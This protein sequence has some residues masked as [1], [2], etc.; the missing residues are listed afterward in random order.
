MAGAQRRVLMELADAL[1]VEVA[2]LDEVAAPPGLANHECGTARMGFRPE[3]S[4]V[5]RNNECWEARGLFL[6][7]GACV[8]SQGTQNPTLTYLAL[9]ARACAYA[10]GRSSGSVS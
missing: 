7:D 9:T 4:V 10:S 3:D 8:P 6:V 2:H 1:D 5:D